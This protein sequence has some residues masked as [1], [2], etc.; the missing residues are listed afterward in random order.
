M[1]IRSIALSASVVLLTGCSAAMVPDLEDLAGEPASSAEVVAEESVALMTPTPTPLT[2]GNAALNGWEFR[3][4]DVASPGKSYRG[5]SA[6]YKA[7]DSWTVVSVGIKNAHSD[8]Q[9]AQDAPFLLFLA[10]VVDSQG[11]EYGVSEI[12]Y[13]YDLEFSRKSFA[14]GEVRSMDLLFNTPPGVRVTELVVETRDFRNPVRI[15]F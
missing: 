3:V 11:N 1:A 7:E 2:T 5:Q 15:G 14:S 9:E 6:V 10:K 8:P 12:D 4:T 13:K